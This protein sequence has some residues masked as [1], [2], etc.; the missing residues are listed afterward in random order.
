VSDVVGKAAEK[1]SYRL[2]PPVLAVVVDAG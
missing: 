1:K 2:T